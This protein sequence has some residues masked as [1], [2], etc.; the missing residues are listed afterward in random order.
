[1]P[2]IEITSGG[3]DIPDGVYPVTLVEIKGPKTVTAQRGPK[4]G[5]EIDLLDWVFAVD[6]G[7]YDGTPIEASTS[8]ASGPKSKMYSYLTALYNGVA[9]Q[10]GATFEVSDLAGRRAFATIKKDAN[11]WPRIENLGAMPVAAQQNGFAKKTGAAVAKPGAPAPAAAAGTPLREQV[12]GGT[13]APT[14]NLPF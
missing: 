14:D 3:V 9:P 12:D 8:T 10:V 7:D 11:G 1:M 6:E 4:A 5:Q 2:F 13:E